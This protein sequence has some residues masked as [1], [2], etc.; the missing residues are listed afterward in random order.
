MIKAE[1]GGQTSKDDPTSPDDPRIVGREKIELPEGVSEDEFVAGVIEMVGNYENDTD[2]PVA[3]VLC[4]GGNC[5]NS[6]SFVGTVLREMGVNTTPDIRVVRTH[7]SLGEG[8][9]TNAPF[10]LPLWNRNVEG[11]KI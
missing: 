9:K 1:A 2:Y 8:A 10:F 4:T 3:G 7:P 5:A 11:L 6:N